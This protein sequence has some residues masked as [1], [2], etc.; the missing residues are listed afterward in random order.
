MAGKVCYI[1]LYVS[2]PTKSGEKHNVNAKHLKILNQYQVSI[3]IN[4]MLMSKEFKKKLLN[5]KPV[6][7]KI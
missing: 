5:V 6:W 1:A 7:V 2:E 4:L 3:S